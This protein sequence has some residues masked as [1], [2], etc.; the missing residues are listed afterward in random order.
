MEQ[1]IIE[2]IGQ[3]KDIAPDI[4]EAYRAQ[5]VIDAWF[6]F[7]FCITT[8]FSWYMLVITYERNEWDMTD[9]L[10]P[11]IWTIINGISTILGFVFLYEGITALF[12]TDYWIVNR[13]LSGL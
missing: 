4:V 1:Q 10:A 12:N 6:N 2:I 11:I 9:D 5:A 7:A 13:M 8:A 3:L